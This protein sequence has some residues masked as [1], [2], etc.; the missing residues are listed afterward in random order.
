M[1]SAAPSGTA[2]TPVNKMFL[3]HT[4][5]KILESADTPGI[6]NIDMNNKP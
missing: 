2:L 4:I 1:L 5:G 3:N 6:E